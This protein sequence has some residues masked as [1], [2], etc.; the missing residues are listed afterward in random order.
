MIETNIELFK[1]TNDTALKSTNISFVLSIFSGTP[2]NDELIDA[3]ENRYS[4]N[5]SITRIQAAMTEDQAMLASL[6]F[7]HSICAEYEGMNDIILPFSDS[8]REM[9]V[10]AE[11]TASWF[12]LYRAQ[13]SYAGSNHLSAPL[14]YSPILI[15]GSVGDLGSGA[16]LEIPG[17][18][19][20]TANTFKCNDIKF[21]VI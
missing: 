5:Y 3:S 11:G 17:S 8:I 4:N 18:V 9:E 14:L 21:S 10:V 6:S 15:I 16:D 2:P 1:E 19:V 12:M 13:S 7:E 20:A